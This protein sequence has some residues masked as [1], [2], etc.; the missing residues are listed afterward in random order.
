MI[1]AEVVAPRADHRDIDATG[2]VA[3]R[4]PLAGQRFPDCPDDHMLVAVAGAASLIA[5][6]DS[7]TAIGTQPLC[8]VR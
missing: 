4:S 6:S 7:M 3:P 2:D 1:C 8:R 5:N